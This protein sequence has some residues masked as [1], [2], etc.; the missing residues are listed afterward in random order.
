M[1]INTSAQ[2]DLH[3]L[4]IQTRSIQ[5][6]LSRVMES[7][8]SDEIKALAGAML[9]VV[10]RDFAQLLS[11]LASDFAVDAQIRRD[12]K[13]EL[14]DDFRAVLLETKEQ[15]QKDTWTTA[16]LMELIENNIHDLKAGWS[17]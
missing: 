12:A 14:L 10:A 2:N 4:T 9:G 3:E 16:A 8:A 13:V 1:R 15:C 5:C 7:L 6:Q 11:A 17:E